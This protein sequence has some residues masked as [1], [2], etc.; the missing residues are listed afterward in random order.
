MEPRNRVPDLNRASYDAIAS[1]WDG[2]R[3]QLT[4]AEHRIIEHMLE[5]ADAATAVLD[6]GCGT[7]RPIAQHIVARGF[8]LTGVDHAPAMLRLATQHL[9]EQTW[10][11]ASLEDF[12]P[13]GDFNAAIA[14][15][16]LFHVPRAAHAKIFAR[17]RQALASGARFAL[18]IGG[19][20]Q[21]AFT[22][23][24]LGRTFYYDSHPPGH[25]VT[26]L[27]RHGFV[28]LHS[29]YLNPPSEGRDKGRFAIVASAS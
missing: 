5:G 13:D 1:R 20:A 28:I 9:P 14:W 15:D 17:V 8:R 12:E 2:V 26:L 22:D 21:P 3:S 25:T 6:L 18:T 11:L 24:M 16:S 23:T 29:E 19:S 4:P 10:V 7:G 27:E